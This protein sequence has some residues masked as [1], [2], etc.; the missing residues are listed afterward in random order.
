M[1][2]VGAGETEC[3]LVVNVEEVAGMDLEPAVGAL[4]RAVHDEDDDIGFPVPGL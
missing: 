1:V 2:E 4:R 3:D